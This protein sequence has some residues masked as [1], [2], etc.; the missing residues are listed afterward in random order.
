MANKKYLGVYE[1][2]KRGSFYVST[3]FTTKDGITIKKCKRGFKTAK[4]AELWKIQTQLEFSQ[5]NYYEFENKKNMLKSVIKKY[6]EYKSSKLKPSTL[7]YIEKRLNLYVAPFFD[8]KLNEIGIEDIQNFYENL[9]KK[10]I[11]S[12]SKNVIIST[13]TTFFEYLD[14]TEM[15]N[16]SIYRKFK[17][18]CVPFKC[19]KSN[20]G[21]YIALEDFKKIIDELDCQD[22]SEHRL[23]LF[24][25]LAFFTG[26]RRGENLGLK[27]SDVS[28]KNGY[29]LTYNK[30]VAIKKKTDNRVLYSFDNCYAVVGYTKTNVTKTVSISEWLYEDIIELKYRLK[31]E[32]ND[33]IFAFENKILELDFIKNK[34]D[35][36]LKKLNLEHIRI[37][38]LRHSHTTM[39]YDLG[40][41][42]KYIAERL[43]HSSDKTSKEVYEHLTNQK[44]KKNDT[45]ITTIKL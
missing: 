26:A 7:Y 23:S 3:S 42:S 25:K 18:I 40:C 39:L 2:S 1:D 13:A 35:K 41:D 17:L 10:D 30:Q 5:K 11:L 9:S 8:K 4:Q 33:Y 20:V 38:D 21:K 36:I 6:I 37:H 27:F 28:S 43:G 16:P 22:L 45:I 29:F 24:L 19:E 15:I 32:D 31:A 14:L 34:L 44:K 12:S